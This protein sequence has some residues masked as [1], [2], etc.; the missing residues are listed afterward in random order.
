M[1]ERFPG[2]DR[3]LAAQIGEARQLQGDD[4]YGVA[5]ARRPFGMFDALPADLRARRA[6]GDFDIGRAQIGVFQ[7]QRRPGD[8]PDP[9]LIAHSIERLNALI[10]YMPDNHR[11]VLAYPA[12]DHGRLTA[13]PVAT[14]LDRLDLRVTLCYV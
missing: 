4:R 9:A 2:I 3:E 13:E 8:A 6:A 1:R 11:V 10:A 14:L 7:V 12:T 5:V